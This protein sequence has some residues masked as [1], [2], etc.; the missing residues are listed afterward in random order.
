MQVGPDENSPSTWNHASKSC[1]N[2]TAE[3]VYGKISFIVLIPEGPSLSLFLYLSHVP[4]GHVISHIPLAKTHSL[5]LS[6]VLSPS[7]EISCKK[8]LLL[9][10]IPSTYLL[11]YLLPTLYLISYSILI[12]LCYLFPLWK[13]N[14]KN[15]TLM[16]LV[17]TSFLLLRCY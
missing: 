10:S 5:S 6:K 12:S 9:D 7:D 15:T 4:K 13:G 11:T 17:V 2:F 16:F 1:L 14:E 8:V 3:A